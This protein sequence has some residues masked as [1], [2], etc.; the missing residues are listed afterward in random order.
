LSLSFFVFG[1]T[2]KIVSRLFFFADFRYSLDSSMDISGR[3][4]PSIPTL[5]AFDIN[6]E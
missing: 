3:I 6:A 5:F 4:K 1:E 2:K